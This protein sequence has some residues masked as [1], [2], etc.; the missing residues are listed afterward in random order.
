M[1]TDREIA[2]EQ[3]AVA[4]V[5]EAKAQGVDLVRLAESAK[6]G[7]YGNKPYCWIGPDHKHGAAEAVDYLIG[8][9]E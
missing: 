2:L 6:I 5:T 4:I 3:A 9:A 1:A 8:R 7:I